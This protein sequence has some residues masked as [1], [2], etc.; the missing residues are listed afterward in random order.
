MKKITTAI[1]LWA[2]LTFIPAQAMAGVS[3]HVSIP[4][5]P[6]ILF[7]LPPAVVVIPDTNSVYAATDIDVDLYFWNGWWWR[8]WEGR[9]YRSRHYDRDW[10]FHNQ[11]PAFYADVHHGWRGYFDKRVWHGHRWNYEKIPYNMLHSNWKQWQIDRHWEVKRKWNVHNY[12]PPN[13]P[14]R[15]TTLKPRPR[16]EASKIRNE[17]KQASPAVR[18]APSVKQGQ[19]PPTQMKKSVPGKPSGLSAAKKPNLSSPVKKGTAGR[20]K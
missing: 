9:W 4:L 7:A 18:K 20:P 8:P 15:K 6:P 10:V 11:T 2:L 1:F 12:Q 19:I 3:I 17:R 14:D 13:R 16:P 5:P